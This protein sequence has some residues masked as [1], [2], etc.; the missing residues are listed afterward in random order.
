MVG[1]DTK[2]DADNTKTD[3]ANSDGAAIN[4]DNSH[5][6]SNGTSTDHSNPTIPTS[7][8]TNLA[9][10]PYVDPNAGQCFVESCRT[11]LSS[12]S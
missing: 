4:T 12:K 7:P 6:D 1:S 11:C 8:N 10:D 2:S 5:T 3:S 9:E